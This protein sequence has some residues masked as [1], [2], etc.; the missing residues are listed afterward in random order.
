MKNPKNLNTTNPYINESSTFFE[1]RSYRH[2]NTHWIKLTTLIITVSLITCSVLGIFSGCAAKPT[3]G[4][5]A[6][7]RSEGDIVEKQK[8]SSDGSQYSVCINYSNYNGALPANRENDI[9]AEMLGQHIISLTAFDYS[10]HFPL[11]ADEILSKYIYEEFQELGYTPDEGVKKISQVVKDTLHITKNSIEYYILDIKN[12]PET[13]QNFKDEH[14]HLFE[15]IG[16]DINK[17]EEVAEYVVK[18]EVKVCWNDIFLIS[19]HFED[20][21]L[22]KY[23]GK[24][25]LSPHMLDND[26]SMDFVC[27][28]REENSGYYE[29]KHAQGLVISNENGY[30][31]IDKSNSKS[32]SDIYYFWIGDA[33]TDVLSGDFVKVKYYSVGMSGKTISDGANIS[34][35]VAVTVEKTTP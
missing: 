8:T 20:C 26:F 14:S 32:G 1:K 15:V 5:W 23:E 34:I 33:Y 25:Y 19:A 13:L 16:L 35:G 28:N 4:E 21:K 7:V 3:S 30:L 24:W 22:Y 12:S 29:E 10:L 17:I 2:K 9:C 6:T 11:F 31:V 27:S 18:E